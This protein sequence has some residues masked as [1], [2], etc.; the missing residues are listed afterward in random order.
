MFKNFLL[1]IL[2]STIF[3]QD[4]TTDKEELKIMKRNNNSLFIDLNKSDIEW[5][6]G[7]KY[8]TKDHFGK[9]K[10]KSG[11]I[12]IS[13]DYKI[14]G[15][16]IIDMKSITNDDIK[17]EWKKNLINHL[18]SPDFFNVDKYDTA[19]IKIISSKIIEK[20][21]NDNFL[22]QI[23]AYLTIKSTTS[24]VRFNTVVDLNSSIK[25]ADGTLIF[26]RNDFGIQYRSEVHIYDPESFWNKVET[27]KSTAMDK[28]IKDEIKI[29]FSIKTKPEFILVE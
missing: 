10:I 28:I 8:S 9:I 14:S 3:C 6:G 4:L 21:N 18:K 11:K 27:T 2:I 16:V 15:T 20:L 12:N 25:T 24:R 13:K 26:D 29:D 5:L 22:M 17:N 7:L 23:D 1:I 19:K